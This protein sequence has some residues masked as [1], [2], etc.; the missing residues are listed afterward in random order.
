MSAA[1]R[2]HGTLLANLAVLVVL[3]VGVYHVGINVLRLQIGRDPFTVRVELA[4]A[5]G[6]YERSEVNY[7][8][9]LVG[10]VTAV[11]LRDGGAVADLRLD[12]G[13]KI[14]ADTD[15]VVASLSAAG[16]QFVDFRPRRSDGPILR[17]GDVIPV[18]RTAVPIST[19]AVVRDVTKLLDQVNSDDLATVVEELAIALD[20]NGGALG[21]LVTSSSELIEALR[22]SLPQTVRLLANARR[23]LDT[24]NALSGDF[25][26]FTTQLRRLTRELRGTDPNVRRLLDTGP[27]AVADLDEFVTALTSPVGALLGNLVVPG[28]LITARLPALEALVIAFPDATGALRTTVRNGKLAIDLHL[29]NNPT[30]SYAGPR[31]TPVDPTR[32]EPDRKRTC[33]SRLPGVQVR[34]SQNAPKPAPSGPGAP[35]YPAV[36]LGYQPANGLVTLPDGTR[37]SLGPVR[38]EGS[39]TA[40]IAILVALLRT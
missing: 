37:Y 11:R 33:T 18:E 31:R 3:V 26:T 32:T 13:T 2:R 35:G 39:M 22:G 10:R 20:G 15:V 29:T 7:R 6:L 40:A 27:E 25:E 1:L 16:E 28:D 8:G 21:R 23:N 4:Q 36:V 19:A 34:G 14:P 9:K 24:A 38:A 12:E 30:C 17:D 5:G